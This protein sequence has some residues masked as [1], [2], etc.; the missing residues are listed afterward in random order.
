MS[1]SVNSFLMAALAVAQVALAAPY[2][3]QA[4]APSADIS[5]APGTYSVNQVRNVNFQRNGPLA[6]AKAYKKFGA[7]MPEKLVAA[8]AKHTKRATGSATTKPVDSSDSEFLTPVQVGTPPQTLMLDFD[9][10]SSD[11]WVFSTETAKQDVNGQTLYQPGK[12]ST[13]QKLTGATWSI[14]YGDGSSS[15]GDVFMD[16]VSVG[17]LAVQSQAVESALKASDEFTSESA[18][19]GLMGLAFSTLNTVQPKQQT[20]FFD[21]ASSNLTS[22]L[23]TADL[24]HNAPGKYNFGFIDATAHNGTIGFTPVDN[25]QGFW[26]FTSNAF[27]VGN[28]QMVPASISGIADTGTT[29]LLLP[30]AVNMAYY[31]QIQGAELSEEDGGYVFPCNAEAPNFSFEVGGQAITIPGQFMNFSA[32]GGGSNLCFG[33]MQS[34]D[35]IGMNIFGDVALK[36]AFVVFDGGNLQLGWA[37]K[38]LTV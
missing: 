6:L 21:T 32:V 30:D 3:L 2:P 7:P 33:G 29:L 22:K 38:P 25:S 4:R 13:A 31:S 9:T 18:L 23:F 27:A 10:G 37:T 35:S 36:S 28:S 14:T 15:S 20:T 12:S 24:Q 11:L 19:S 8:V 34:S 5:T 17:G 16:V 1:P 26:G